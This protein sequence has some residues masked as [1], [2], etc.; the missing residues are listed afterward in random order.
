MLTPSGLLI[1]FAFQ[2][3]AA[4]ESTLYVVNVCGHDSVGP[5]LAKSMNPVDDTYIEHNGIDNLI[6]PISVS[7][8]KRLSTGGFTFCI[9]VVVHTLLI[10]KC[11]SGHHLYQHL[12]E[13]LL[14]L[15]IEW[16]QTECGVQLLRQS[17]LLL[18]D[19]YYYSDV[20]RAVK[21]EDEILRM[22][23]ELLKEKKKPQ[24]SEKELTSHLPDALNVSKDGM[25]V[26]SRPLIQEVVASPGLKKGFLKNGSAKLYGPHG[27]SEGSG[28]TPDPLSHIPESLRS[29]CKIIDTRDLDRP[30]DVLTA[31]ADVSATPGG[32]PRNKVSDALTG[33]PMEYEQDEWRKGTVEQRESM[34]VVY[35]TV[36][37]D[38]LTISDIDLSVSDKALG[39]DGVVTQLPVSIVTD[40]VRAKFVKRTRRLSVTCQ[41]AE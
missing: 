32:L 23:A 13:K 21:S 33:S 18:G 26:S 17:C 12:T 5:P 16:V 28:K 15:S 10:K 4:D 41:I 25:R 34:L 14:V 20:K 39:I 36:P 38:V 29:K 7:E 2:A 30:C 9:D 22:A 19:P 6:V 37:D 11:V 24:R 40:S 35:F 27:S 3:Y 8:P 31:S 1:G